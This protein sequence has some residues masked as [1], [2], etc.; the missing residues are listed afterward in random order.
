[1][2]EVL[3]AT[4]KPFAA[5]AVSNIRKIVEDA[6]FTLALLEKYTEKQEF[7]EAVATASAL[8]VRSDIVDKDII[9]AGK[10][11]KI[12]VRAGAGYDN[13]DLAACTSKGIV[14]MNTPGQNANAVA[15]LAFGLMVYLI[16]NGFN[17]T[18]GFELKGKTIGLHAYGHIGRI[19]G[20]IAKGFGMN[21][22][23]FD[24]FV[25]K[26]VVENDGIEY[27]PDL[28]SLYTKSQFV[29][30]HIPFTS[31]TK[32]LINYDLLRLMPKNAVLINTARA[33]IIDEAGLLKIFEERKDFRYGSDITPACKSEIEAKYSGRYVFTAKKMGA[34][35]SEA[36]NNAGIA[37]ARQIVNFLLNG[38]CTFQVN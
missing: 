22:C 38:D 21:V 27:V 12:V 11:L 5:E 34:Q 28:Q 31:E 3:V 2:A 19:V 37:A 30:L 32:A 10:N 6:G 9:E 15:E 18:S 33:E 14:A 17:G 36:N 35:T 13:L 16:R 23:A 24:P 4:D 1:M 8:I 25:D 26:V 29:S 20:R 7:T